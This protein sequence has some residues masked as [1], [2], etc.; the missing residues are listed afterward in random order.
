[1]AIEYEREP[2]I[3]ERKSHEFGIAPTKSGNKAVSGRASRRSQKWRT[4]AKPTKQQPIP[5]I[6]LV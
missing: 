2:R 6:R 3:Q 1:M 5:V 4:I